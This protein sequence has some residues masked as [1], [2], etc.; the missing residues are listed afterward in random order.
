MVGTRRLQAAD[1]TVQP[2]R[3]CRPVSSSTSRHSNIAHRVPAQHD[4]H[5]GHRERHR[6]EPVRRL[7]KRARREGQDPLEDVVVERH[8]REGDRQQ[9]QPGEVAAEHQIDLGGDDDA[10]GG[11]GERLRCEQPAR[12]EELGDMVPDDLELVDRLGQVVKPEAEPV[13]HRLCLVVVVQRGQVMPGDV[14]ADLDESRAHLEAEQQP[15]QQEDDGQQ[16]GRGGVGQK[17]WRGS[18]S[19]P[20]ASPRRTR[21]R[22]GRC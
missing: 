11:R 21:R 12:R 17:R 5:R 15:A 20:A 16:R 2:S 4:H 3:R 7:G 18:R 14:V 8:H 9:V 22:P 1:A 10:T 13:G 19:P 6:G